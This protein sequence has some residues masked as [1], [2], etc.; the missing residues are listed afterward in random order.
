MG[1]MILGLIVSGIP[2]AAMYFWLK[3][4]NDAG[5]YK[6]ACRKALFGGALASVLVVL[7]SLVLSVFGSAVLH[8]SDRS[9]LFQAFWKA[10]FVFALSEETS[11]FLIFRRLIKKTDHAYSVRDLAAF[12]TIIGMGFGIL[13]G[14]VYGFTTNVIQMIVRG[15]ALGHGGYG[16]LMGKY[17]GEGRLTGKKSKYLLS[18]IVPFLLHAL[19]DFTLSDAVEQWNDNL[20][21]VPVTLAMVSVIL[22]FVIIRW[23]KKARTDE[24]LITPLVGMK[25]NEI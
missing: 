8:S 14:I 9:P 19:Y 4:Q 20:V 5:E 13:E 3:K 22:V 11:K 25:D 2:A 15:V 12:M 24:T 6:A 1:I 7:F 18:F 23:M 16:F 17:Y 21:V 10:F